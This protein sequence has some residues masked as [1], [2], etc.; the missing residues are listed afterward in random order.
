MSARKLLAP[1]PDVSP[2]QEQAFFSGIR[3]RN[4]TFKTTA[5]RRLDDLNHL[6]IQQWKALG[7][8]PHNLLDAGASSGI[9]SVEW[10][11]ALS[12]A[13][14]DVRVVA[15]DSCLKAYLVSVF[16][17]YEVLLDSSGHILQHIVFGTGVRP[18]R[19]K[20]DF[21]TGHVVLSSLLNYFACRILR[22]R[23]ARL[24]QG[25]EVM[26]V[27]SRVRRSAV[28][29]AEDDVLGLNAQGFVRRFDAIRAANLLNCG[30][31]SAAQIRTA[32]LNLKDRLSGPNGFLIVNRTHN[33]GKNHG[34][35]F[36]LNAATRFEILAR[37]GN[38]S[39]IEEIVLAA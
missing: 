39:E 20:L 22:R 23:I 26:L 3:L 16:R 24:G 34:T 6:V 17:N 19:R 27:S 12:A 8:T 5:E 37:L 15:T 7:A 2:R 36:Q 33:D 4:G 35:L 10:Q 13:G 11:E 32:I 21:L 31:F 29:F 30:Y 38:G 25:E 9:S 1:G 28:T 18:W 14:F